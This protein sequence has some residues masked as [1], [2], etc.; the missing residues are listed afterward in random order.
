MNTV[1][2]D[3]ENL[4]KLYLVNSSLA[5]TQTQWTGYVTVEPTLLSELRSSY[6]A[7]LQNFGDVSNI[8]LPL[9]IDNK[10]DD[11]ELTSLSAG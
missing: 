10:I 2:C 1:P 9:E 5:W 4:K 11:V 7:N 8:P 6:S 3:F